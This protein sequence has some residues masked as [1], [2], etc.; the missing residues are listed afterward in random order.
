MI[1]ET[2]YIY[3][4]I[5]NPYTSTI[6]SYLGCFGFFWDVEFRCAQAAKLRL[7]HVMSLGRSCCFEEV[8]PNSVRLKCGTRKVLFL[9]HRLKQ[10]FTDLTTTSANAPWISFLFLFTSTVHDETDE[11]EDRNTAIQPNT[12]LLMHLKTRKNPE[13]PEIPETPETPEHLPENPPKIPQCKQPAFGFTYK[14]I[15]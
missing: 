8:Q 15:R 10:I 9:T 6:S 14:L 4:H 11:T 13:T 7:V 3:M 5:Y 2:I 12:L 1:Q